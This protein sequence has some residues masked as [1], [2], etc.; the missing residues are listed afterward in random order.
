M[1]NHEFNGKVA[2]ITGAAQGIGFELAS[3]LYKS[4]ASVWIA[5]INE[6]GANIAR[7]EIDIED[8]SK[9]GS[10]WI[11]VC[12]R[13]SVQDAVDTC[14]DTFGKVDILINNAGIVRRDKVEDMAIEMWNEVLD[15]NLTGSFLCSQAVIPFMKEIGGG[16]ILNVSSVSARVPGIGLSAYCC[17]KAANEMFTKILAAEV[18]PYGIRVNAYA[19]GVTKTAM[20]QKL[21]EERGEDKLN[22]I[23]LQRFGEVN[24]IAEL[25]LFLCSDRSSWITGETI[26]IDGGTMIVNCPWKAW[27]NQ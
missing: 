26:H 27:I 20:T 6:T 9:V 10:C 16:V 25:A 2:M 1:F 17:A 21:I 7:S 24:D 11:D 18:A 14:V 8:L 4:G 22:Q 23:A 13:R 15:I 12:D 5:D 3:K 19:P